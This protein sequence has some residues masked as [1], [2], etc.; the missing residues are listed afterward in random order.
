MSLSS[1][2]TLDYTSPFGLT[3]SPYLRSLGK[4]TEGGR[5]VMPSA[6][7]MLNQILPLVICFFQSPTNK[8]PTGVP[9]APCHSRVRSVYKRAERY[10]SGCQGPQRLH[11]VP[12]SPCLDPK[13]HGKEQ[14]KQ[15][16]LEGTIY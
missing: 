6:L 5:V 4:D 9:F 8:E 3:A 7:V 2:E 12:L 16:Q 13:H 15:A 14:Q 10:K 11:M 1:C